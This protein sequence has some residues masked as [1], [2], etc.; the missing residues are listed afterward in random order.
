MLNREDKEM[1]SVKLCLFVCLFV[2]FWIVLCAGQSE[3]S[4]QSSEEGVAQDELL[5][6]NS[7]R[8]NLLKVVFKSSR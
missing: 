1:L 3:T 5:V 2:C 8:K 6:E 7:F 4:L